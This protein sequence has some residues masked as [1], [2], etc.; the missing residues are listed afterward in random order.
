MLRKGCSFQK[1][2]RELKMKGEDIGKSD[3]KG[4]RQGE[5]KKKEE[6]GRREKGLDNRKIIKKNNNDGQEREPKVEVFL[7]SAIIFF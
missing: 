1:E 7:V 6:K 2:G 5:E 4:K 3:G